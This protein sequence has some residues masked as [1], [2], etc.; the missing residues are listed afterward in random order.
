MIVFALLLCVTW[1]L[2]LEKEIGIGRAPEIRLGTVP[3]FER[4]PEFRVGPEF[5]RG[6]EFS[7]SKYHLFIKENI[8]WTA[9]FLSFNIIEIIK[10]YYSRKFGQYK[11]N[12]KTKTSC[13][14]YGCQW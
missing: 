4:G 12:G 8:L 2:S 6:P 5:A 10:T 3:E 7:F 13:E 9:T 1:D 14:Q 11:N